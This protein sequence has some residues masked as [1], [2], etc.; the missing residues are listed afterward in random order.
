MEIFV[1][2][3]ILMIKFKKNIFICNSGKFE[4]RV[5]FLLLKYLFIYG[6]GN[7]IFINGIK[8]YDEL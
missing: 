2:G 4:I 8:S 3:W 1:S 6:L 5:F 7:I